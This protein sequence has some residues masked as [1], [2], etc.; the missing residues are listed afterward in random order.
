M[1]RSSGRSSI[2]ISTSALIRSPSSGSSSACSVDR[3]HERLGGQSRLGHKSARIRGSGR[4]SK[5]EGG[6]SALRTLYQT[7]PRRRRRQGWLTLALMLLGAVAEV[8]SIGA[9][10]PFLSIVA[11][12]G[13]A[14]R[15]PLIGGWIGQ[16][17]QGNELV[18]ITAAAFI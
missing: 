12:P 7:L 4:V 6:G 17:P 5:F 16:L 18:S 15:M 11:N 9:I 8:L 2:P 1:M 3:R 14:V 10:L 13:Q